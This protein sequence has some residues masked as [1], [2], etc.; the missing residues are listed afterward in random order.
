MNV[1]LII[2]AAMTNFH[3]NFQWFQCP[4]S[5]Q[6]LASGC[7]RCSRYTATL[8]LPSMSAWLRLDHAPFDERNAAD[9]A[10]KTGMS[11]RSL[12]IAVDWTWKGVQ[13]MGK[14][15]KMGTY[16]ISLICW[17]IFFVGWLWNTSANLGT[18]ALKNLKLIL[19][20][21][22]HL[23]LKFKLSPTDPLSWLVPLKS[24][25]QVGHLWGIQ[26]SPNA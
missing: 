4:A 25:L 21:I 19:N 10:Q 3:N 1:W 5:S 9:W 13:I 24:L 14:K 17:Q 23:L 8:W 26:V 15:N 7:T 2:F 22:D 18:K 20:N 11:Q 16:Q 12:S 6:N